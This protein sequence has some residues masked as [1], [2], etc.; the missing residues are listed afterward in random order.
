LTKVVHNLS[1]DAQ[2][3]LDEKHGGY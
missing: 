1:K 2:V 3:N